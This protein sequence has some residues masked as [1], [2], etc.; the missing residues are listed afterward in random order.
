MSKSR[1]IRLEEGKIWVQKKK[2]ANLTK[3]ERRIFYVC[4]F[5]NTIWN[6]IRNGKID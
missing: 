3:N 4:F 5:L 1:L 6:R 2:F